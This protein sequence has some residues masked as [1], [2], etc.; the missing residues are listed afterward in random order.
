MKCPRCG[1]LMHFEEFKNTQ[2][3]VYWTYD[4]WR[5]VFCGE[6]LDPLILLN[7]EVER[8]RHDTGEP[9][10]LGRGRYH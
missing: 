8:H 1:G 4:G 5:C 6:V 2:N 7:R 3:D 10:A 9:V